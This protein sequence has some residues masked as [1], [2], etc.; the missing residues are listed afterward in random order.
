MSSLCQSFRPAGLVLTSVVLAGLLLP[1]ALGGDPT[2]TGANDAKPAVTVAVDWAAFLDR[3]DLILNRP[4]RNYF[5]APFVGDGLLG[6]MVWQ[7]SDQALRLEIGRTDVTDHRTEP[8]QLEAVARKGRLPIGHFTL[9]TVGKITGG[10]MRLRLYD[11]EAVGAITTDQGTL[12]W[13]L[14][15]QTSRPLLAM[16]VTATGGESVS[17]EWRPDV[18]VVPRK[19]SESRTNPPPTL[20]QRDGVSFCLQ[21]RSAGGDYCTAWTE[22]N[23]G[24]GTRRLLVTIADDWPRAGS[25][26]TALASLGAAR[27]ADFAALLKEHRDWWHAYYPASFVSVPDARMESF[28]WIQIYKLASSIRKG[29]PLCDLMGPWYKPSGWPGI[30]FNLNTQGLYW[31]LPSAN[32]L[33]LMENLSDALEKNMQSLIASVPKEFQQDSAAISRCTGTDLDERFDRWKEYGNLTWLCHDL[34]LQYRHSM[35]DRFLRNRLYPLLRRSVNLYLHVL[36]KGDDGRYHMPSA[37]CPESFDGPDNNYDLSSIRWGCDTLLAITKRLNIRDELAPK[38]EDV[39]QNLVPFPQ[40]EHGF[41]GGPGKAAPRGHRHWSHMLMIYPYYTVN[42]DQPENRDVIEQSWQWW[43]GPRVPNAWSQA[44]MSSVASM[45]GHGDDALRHMRLS[46][47]SRNIASNTMHTEGGNPC[48]ETHG[49]MCQMLHDMLMTSWGQ[50]I[51]IFPGVPDAWK[52]AVFRDLRA[53]GAFLVSAERKN[54]RTQWVL[55]KSLAGEPCRIVPSL[56]GEVKATVP[57]KPLG[58]GCYELT[59]AQGEEALLYTG[60]QPPSPVVTPLPIAPADR[61]PYG[62]K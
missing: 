4:A 23:A 46:L 20:D 38:W 6:A 58:N 22:T 36:T 27:Q 54:G 35:D 16:D 40:D 47:A 41:S 14:L 15:A 12:S 26:A 48:S 21:R 34:W 33:E 49:M 44:V 51:R 59:L 17:W 3:H 28:Y 5:E 32:R 7:E 2:R 60:G 19:P 43:A 29:G 56:A 39:R 37:H 10:T 11:A 31:P 62:L 1:P 30:W 50:R 42:W 13:R 25:D 18:S 61:N 55:I 45:M 9:S 53:E 52:D 8:E 57:M 24:N